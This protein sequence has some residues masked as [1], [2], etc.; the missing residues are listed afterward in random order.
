MSLLFRLRAAA[1]Q[2][3][4]ITIE[5]GG[6]DP[7][8]LIALARQIGERENCT[9]DCTTQPDRPHVLSVRFARC[10]STTAEADQLRQP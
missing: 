4:D 10:P 1:R 5:Y 6:G 9:A 8:E 7:V 2:A 3:A